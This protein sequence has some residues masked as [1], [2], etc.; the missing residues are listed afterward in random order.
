[1]KVILEETGLWISRPS[2]GE[3]PLSVEL[4]ISQPTEGLIEPEGGGRADLLSARAGTSIFSQHSWVLGLGT[5]TGICTIGFPHAQD[6]RLDW[7]YVTGF[8]GPPAGRR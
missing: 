3:R 7:N 4:D 8:P 5:Q 1:M 6:L 2:K